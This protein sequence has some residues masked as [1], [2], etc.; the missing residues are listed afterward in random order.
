MQQRT[1]IGRT[2]AQLEKKDLR[3]KHLMN[4]LK[5]EN[6]GNRLDFSVGFQVVELGPTGG[7]NR[8][9]HILGSVEAWYKEVLLTVRP[10]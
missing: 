9:R 1:D 4:L 6:I 5:S 3:D 2:V 10:I 8:E 7:S